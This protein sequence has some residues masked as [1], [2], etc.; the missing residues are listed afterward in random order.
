MEPEDESICTPPELKKIANDTSLN[1]LP[2]TSKE[3]YLYS[4]EKFKEWKIQKK[5]SITSE[6]VMIAYFT[7][8]AEKLKPSSLWSIHSRLKSTIKVHENIDI[9]SFTKLTAFLKRKSDGY[10]PKKSKVLTDNDITTFL[11][12]APNE[13]YLATKVS[14]YNADAYS[15]FEPY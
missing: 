13:I 8:L 3:K 9:S 2:P 5:T 12:D 15:F 7:E 1:L 6:N 4:Y 14:T 11:N 10:H